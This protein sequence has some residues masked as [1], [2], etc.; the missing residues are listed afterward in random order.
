MTIQ[1]VFSFHLKNPEQV[2][3]EFIT[4]P[5]NRGNRS[6]GFPIFSTFACVVSH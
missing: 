6:T 2:M 5:Y 4:D 3:N 1:K